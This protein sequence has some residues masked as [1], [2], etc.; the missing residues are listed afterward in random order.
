MD[1]EEMFTLEIRLLTKKFPKKTEEEIKEEIENAVNIF[2]SLKQD[3]TILTFNDYE[4]NWIKRCAEELLQRDLKYRNLQS[5][6]ENGYSLSFFENLI[7][8]DLKREIFP[9]VGTLK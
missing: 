2:R 4:K 8:L 1:I 5:Y 3:P 9:K 7:S 6:S